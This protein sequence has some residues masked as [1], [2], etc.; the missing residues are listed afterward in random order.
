MNVLKQRTVTGIQNDRKRQEY[1]DFV[2]K[3]IVGH[4]DYI[5]KDMV[6]HED[7]INNNMVGHESYIG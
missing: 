5:N 1:G 3:D 2:N 6:E 7:F 4:E